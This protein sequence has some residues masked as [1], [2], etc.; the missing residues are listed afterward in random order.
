MFGSMTEAMEIEVLRNA[1]ESRGVVVDA[2]APES[3]TVETFLSTYE[4]SKYDVVWVVSHGEFDHWSPSRV[5][6]QIARDRTAVSL[7][8]LH[9]KAPESDSRRLLV[10]NVCD[11]ARFEEIGMIPKI[12]LAPGLAGP[13]Q[14]TVSHLWPVM[15]FPSAAF[16]AYLAHHLANGSPYFEAYKRTLSSVRKHATAIAAELEDLYGARFELMERLSMRDE[17]FSPIEFSGSAAFFQ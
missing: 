5:K 17:D 6:L 10:L 13:A 9:R 15:G 7:E 8:D 12:G 1:F 2:F 3:C 14:A 4:H 16:G 11:G